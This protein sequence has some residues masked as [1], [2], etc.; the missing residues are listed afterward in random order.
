MCKLCCLNCKAF[1]HWDGDY[2]CV[3]KMVILSY[4]DDEDTSPLNPEKLTKWR[5]CIDFRFEDKRVREVNWCMV[6]KYKAK[7]KNKNKQT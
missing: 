6:D 5:F 4:G 1:A 7:I 3:D 2:C